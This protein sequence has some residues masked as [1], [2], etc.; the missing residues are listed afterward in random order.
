MASEGTATEG[1]EAA[2]RRAGSGCRAGTGCRAIDRSPRRR[3][4]A[5]LATAALLA[6]GLALGTTGAGAAGAADAP[7]VTVTVAQ[8]IDDAT[9]VDVLL[10]G[11]ICALRNVGYATISHRLAL[12]AG[13]HALS[14]LPADGSCTSPVVLAETVVD[15]PGGSDL[16]VAARPDAEGG[17]LAVQTTDLSDVP[18]YRTRVRLLNQT[19]EPLTATVTRNPNNVAPLVVGELAPGAASGADPVVRGEHT[20]VVTTAWGTLET[21]L[22]LS[23]R[24]VV[25]LY[26]TGSGPDAQ[27]VVDTQL[28][29]NAVL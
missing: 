18:A 12:P 21:T 9:A 25:D 5:A 16:S 26:V 27:L 11:R 2:V 3:A 8:G 14:V 4:G 13:P 22:T 15:A 23:D 29:A 10:D 24:R 19:S 6:T 7:N 1:T 20:V 28:A 17:V